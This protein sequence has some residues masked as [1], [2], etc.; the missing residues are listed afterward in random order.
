M[1]PN[2][3]RS[4]AAQVIW[5]R[6][7]FLFF[8][9]FLSLY[10]L[11]NVT[12]ILQCRNFSRGSRGNLSSSRSS[13][14]NVIKNLSIDGVSIYICTKIK[15]IWFL[16]LFCYF[17]IV[18]WRVVSMGSR[19]LTNSSYR[20]DLWIRLRYGKWDRFIPFFESNLWA[21]SYFFFLVLRLLTHW[22]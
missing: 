10:D 4:V 17:V 21:C 5:L 18:V 16:F 12:K 22:R 14:G 8:F 7:S 2:N 6:L 3:L 20:S 11:L 9:S 15:I 1:P 13:Y 19:F